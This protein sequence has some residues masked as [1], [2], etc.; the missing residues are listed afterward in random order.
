MAVSLGVMS[1]YENLDGQLELEIRQSNLNS[2][3]Y[4]DPWVLVV[5]CHH[6][7]KVIAM[8]AI[9]ATVLEIDIANHNNIAIIGT[10]GMDRFMSRR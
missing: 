10:L 2:H 4:L 8:V 6:I 1:F 3:S 5:V 9:S 7:K